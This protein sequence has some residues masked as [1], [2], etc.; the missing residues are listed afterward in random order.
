M[1]N[2]C[3]S[4]TAVRRVCV[5]RQPLVTPELRPS[6]TL[7]RQIWYRLV[8]SDSWCDFQPQWYAIWEM[9]MGF[10]IDSDDIAAARNA[11]YLPRQPLKTA[12]GAQ[13]KRTP[14][15]DKGELGGA[16]KSHNDSNSI[17]PI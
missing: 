7:D 13:T 11:A 17:Q 14:V 3:E 5:Y 8:V 15:I 12:D 6:I 10:T 16:V 4:V 2:L 9:V 1:H